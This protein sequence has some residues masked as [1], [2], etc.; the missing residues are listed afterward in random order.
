MKVKMN[1]APAQGRIPYEHI[2][3]AP[4]EFYKQ[5]V[6]RYNTILDTEIIDT[7]FDQTVL[8]SINKKEL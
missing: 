7:A 8:S 3:H 5:L 4:E 6:K 1:K 2:V